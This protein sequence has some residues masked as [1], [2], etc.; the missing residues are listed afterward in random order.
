MPISNS[1]L[2]PD[3]LEF[4]T[5]SPVLVTRIQQS[6]FNMNSG[7]ALFTNGLITQGTLSGRPAFGTLGRVYFATDTNE[8]FYDTGA[9]WFKINQGLIDIQFFTATGTWTRPLGCQKIYVEAMGGG[10]G[11][12][13]APATGAGQNSIGSGGGAG[14][15]ATLFNTAPP[16]TAAVTIGAAGAGVSGANGTGGGSTT[17]AALLTCNGGA[18]GVAAGPSSGQL[19]AQGGLGGT[20]SSGSINGTAQSGGLAVNINTNAWAGYGANSL[21]GRGGRAFTGVAATVTNGEAANGFGAA[22]SGGVLFASTAAAIGG[23]GTPGLV[24]VLSFG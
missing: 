12:G 3:P 18:P 20:S 11:G 9:A 22:G 8:F 1:V 15:Y 6:L 16:A 2:A 14:A 24:V 21:Y 4:P 10:G 19:N 13:G 17:F 5:Y 7:I 23:A